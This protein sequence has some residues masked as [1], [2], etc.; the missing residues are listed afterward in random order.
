MDKWYEI[1]EGI[2]FTTK[3][4]IYLAGLA[5]FIIALIVWSKSF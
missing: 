1:E 3:L 5:L 2:N 4:G